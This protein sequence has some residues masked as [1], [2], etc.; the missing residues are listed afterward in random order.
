MIRN[1]LLCTSSACW[2]EYC[3]FV[4]SFFFVWDCFVIQINNTVYHYALWH[5]F[6]TFLSQKKK[7]KQTSYIAQS[8]SSYLGSHYQ[9]RNELFFVRSTGLQLLFLSKQIIF[10]LFDLDFKSFFLLLLV[11]GFGCNR[12]WI[13]FFLFL[14]IKSNDCTPD[15]ATLFDRRQFSE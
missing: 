2:S 11:F 3:L 10:C 13:F 7:W 8:G 15:G 5:M 12:I 6:Q 1:K 4:C 9:D 14:K